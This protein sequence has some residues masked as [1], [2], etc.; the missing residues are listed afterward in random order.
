MEEKIKFISTKHIES[1]KKGDFYVVYYIEA[2][3]PITSFVDI[4]TFEKI[5]K[6]NLKEL[7]D[8]TATYQ[9]RKMGNNLI[10]TLI[11]IK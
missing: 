7:Q 4:D 11:D 2:H 1:K 5:A 6:K 9:I 10:R 8:C 3:E